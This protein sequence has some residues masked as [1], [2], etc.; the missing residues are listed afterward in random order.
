VHSGW[1]TEKA[2]LPDTVAVTG[3][4]GSALVTN[5]ANERVTD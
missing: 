3:A 5:A 4:S 1:P 2:S